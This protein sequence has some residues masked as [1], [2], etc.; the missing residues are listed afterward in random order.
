M[1][2][3]RTSWRKAPPATPVADE[4]KNSDTTDSQG[5]S[6]A[7]TVRPGDNLSEIAQENEL[8]GGWNA[9]YDANRGTV[10]IDPDLIVPGQSL[11]LTI[12]SEAKAE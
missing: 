3:R 5:A 11:D 8:P 4:V 2:H 6:G 9:L 7:Y 12:G 1:L 10:G